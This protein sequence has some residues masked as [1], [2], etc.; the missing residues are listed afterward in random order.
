MQVNGFTVMPQENFIS[1]RQ[2]RMARAGAALSQKGLAEIAG[3][4]ERTVVSF[5]KG[6]DANRATRK[7]LRTA[8]EREGAT[9]I[10]PD[11]V[12]FQGEAA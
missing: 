12:A 9:F 11:G 4:A 8:L 3:L 10:T 7:V 1:A 2:C 6:A 5:E